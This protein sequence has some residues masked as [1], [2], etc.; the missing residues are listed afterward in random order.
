MDARW[1]SWSLQKAHTVP[2]LGQDIWSRKPQPKVSKGVVRE[3]APNLQ[4]PI[5]TQGYNQQG[6]GSSLLR[7]R[8]RQKERL[9]GKGSGSIQ[10]GE[11]TEGDLINV[12]KYMKRSWRQMDEARFSGWCTTIGQGVIA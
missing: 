2:I 5:S 6:S 12:Y 7:G 1:V 11:K 9:E 3:G 10:P 8:G 4:S